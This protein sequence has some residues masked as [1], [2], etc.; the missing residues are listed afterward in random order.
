MED[1]NFYNHAKMI[2]YTFADLNELT[3]EGFVRKSELE[4][5]IFNSLHGAFFNAGIEAPISLLELSFEIFNDLAFDNMIVARTD[6]FAGDYYKVNAAKIRTWRKEYLAQSEIHRNFLVIGPSYLTD[7]VAGF[8]KQI[9]AANPTA[10]TEISSI[11]S[12]DGDDI[13]S[14]D[15]LKQIDVND[16]NKDKFILAVSTALEQLDQNDLTNEQK[17]QSRVYLIAAKELAD[18]PEPPS[19]IIWE[20]IQRAGAICGIL[21]LFLP[22][23]MKVMS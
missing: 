17:S 1:K 21:G 22:I 6:E 12:A 9:E 16:T 20:L 13:R 23:F 7:A 18:T 3:T 4:T 11:S 2:F 15:G 10:E 14:W 19:D 5:H 8:A